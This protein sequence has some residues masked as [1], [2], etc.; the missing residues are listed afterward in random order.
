MKRKM[1]LVQVHSCL[2]ATWTMEAIA[3]GMN[4]LTFHSEPNSIGQ[5]IAMILA[6]IALLLLIISI[7]VKRE[8]QDERSR[9]NMRK[10]TNKSHRFI[11]MIL[12]LAFMYVG[13]MM[14]SGNTVALNYSWIM[15]LVAFLCGSESACFIYYEK[16]ER[17]IC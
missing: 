8:P 10:A 11:L 13:Y 3:N 16:S 1:T 17:T 2:V 9:E 14:L 4:L 6:A 5:L 15:I 12:T 7:V